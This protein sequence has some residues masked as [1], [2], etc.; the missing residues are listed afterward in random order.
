MDLILLR[1]LTRAKNK[2]RKS[3]SSVSRHI[4]PIT[5][6]SCEGKH[7]HCILPMN[8]KVTFE[9]SFYRRSKPHPLVGKISNFEAGNK[10][11]SI[12]DPKYSEDGA[13]RDC[14]S[15]WRSL[16]Y[17]L[18]AA[19]SDVIDIDRSELDGLF[20]P[21]DNNSKRVEIVIYDNIASGAG[22]SKKIAWS[23]MMYSAVLLN[24]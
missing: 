17:A 21:V 6:S 22:H 8:F 10:V 14:S 18:L 16:T 20:K 19:A 2:T 23:L 24:L 11:D 15:F 3:R 1:V 7:I 4:N 5:G 13:S 12:A 9:A